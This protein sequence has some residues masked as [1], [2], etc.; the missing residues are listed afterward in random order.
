[1]DGGGPKQADH[2]NGYENLPEA[3][4][5]QID[6]I[7]SEV[8]EKVS[9]ILNIWIVKKTIMPLMRNLLSG[10][11]QRIKTERFSENEVAILLTEIWKRVNN[12]FKIGQGK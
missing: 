12:E 4:R 10:F 8:M 3:K 5:L 9:D 7:V 1:M 6:Q 2:C 11:S